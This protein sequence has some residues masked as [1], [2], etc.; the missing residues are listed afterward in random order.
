MEKVNYILELEKGLENE[1]EELKMAFYN[2]NMSRHNIFK[3]GQ[4]TVIEFYL[5][6]NPLA[7]KDVF[8]GKQVGDKLYIGRLQRIQDIRDSWNDF[9]VYDEFIS[10]GTVLD[11]E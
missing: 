5:D 8:Y 1:I 9:S 2:D 6:S 4:Y 3:Q 10:N 7:A 11:F